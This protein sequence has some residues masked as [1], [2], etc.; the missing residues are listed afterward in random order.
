[1]SQLQDL[2]RHLVAAGYTHDPDGNGEFL[3]NVN[4]DSSL[5]CQLWSPNSAGQEE[6]IANSVRP[7]STATYL[8][9]STDIVVVFITASSA[10]KAYTFDGDD[11]EWS[12][13][14][15]FG[16]IAKYTVHPN[17]KV[18]GAVDSGRI[19]VVFQDSSHRLILLEFQDDA[20]TSTVLPGDPVVG[21]PISTMSF[22]GG[23]QVFYLSA[24]DNRIHGIAKEDG[25]WVDDIDMQFAFTEEIKAFFLAPGQTGENE[26]Y[27]LTGA[28]AL[29][30]ASDGG[31][32]EL[33]AVQNGK[34]VPATTEEAD[35]TYRTYYRDGRIKSEVSMTGMRSQDVPHYGRNRSWHRTRY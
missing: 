13:S 21:T 6:L 12:E 7:N 25:A 4:A 18:A 20:W 30:K 5:R 32:M 16:A 31:L 11:E 23:L 29:L 15:K 2:V 9:T 35:V 24:K 19:H 34:Y 3:L 27:V 28:N 8:I 17:G 26:A 1:M 10:L 33:G 22:D 14:D